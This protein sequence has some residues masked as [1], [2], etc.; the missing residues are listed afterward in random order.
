M[1]YNENGQLV[2]ATTPCVTE[3]FEVSA[4]HEFEVITLMLGGSVIDPNAQPGMQLGDPSMSPMVATQQYR[5]RYIF[6]APNDYDESYVDVVGTV[7]DN[8]LNLDGAP[9]T[10]QGTPLNTAWSIYR[11]PLGPGNDGAHVLAADK[12][13]GAQVIGYGNYTSY[14]YPAGLDLVQISAPPPPPPPK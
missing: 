7:G 14:Q 10:V 8:T 5:T 9:L 3:S 12:P 11:V 1:T 2:P 4:N 6:L 13:F